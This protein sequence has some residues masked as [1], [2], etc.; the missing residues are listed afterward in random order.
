MCGNPCSPT[1]LPK[2]SPGVF[3]SQGPHSVTQVAA[4][5][6]NH[7]GPPPQQGLAISIFPH[8]I[9]HA[10][11]MGL[12]PSGPHLVTQVVAMCTN[13]QRPHRGGWCKHRPPLSHSSGGLSPGG[14]PST[15]QVHSGNR[16]SPHSGHPK[17][18]SGLQPPGCMGLASASFPHSI[19]HVV[20]M[21]LQSFGTPLSHP[22]A[23]H[24]LQQS[25]TP[26]PRRAALTST[27]FSH[28]VSQAV[29]EGPQPSSWSPSSVDVMLGRG[30][31]S[32]PVVHFHL[33]GSV[34]KLVM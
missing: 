24:G 34:V 21:G 9:T 12:Q 18:G 23:S 3:N 26:I 15:C 17:S 16:G 32:Q 6:S 2:W 19:T 27:S 4:V 30:P 10:V 11:A 33:G 13:P 20:A 31:A 22:S 28:S 14:L 8:S 25:G 1:R 29:V 5:I 7:Q